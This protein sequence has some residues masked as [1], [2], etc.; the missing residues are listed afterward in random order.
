MISRKLQA[1]TAITVTL[2]AGYYWGATGDLNPDRRL[3]ATQ[4]E[5]VQSYLVHSRSWSYAEDGTLSEVMEADRVEHFARNDVSELERPRFYS[6]DGNDRTWSATA[7]SGRLRHRPEVL[8]LRSNV[9]LTNDQAG[10]TLETRVMTVDLRHKTAVSRVPVTIRQAGNLL[11]ADGM[12]VDLRSETM[13][14]QPNV[15]SLYVPT[16]S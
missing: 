7:D 16:G 4:E 12:E 10:A 3:L 15:E 6:H 8:V 9:L 11:Q 14:L 13:H 1:L 2:V 5:L